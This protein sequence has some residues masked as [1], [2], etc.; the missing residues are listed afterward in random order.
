MKRFTV[1][2]HAAWILRVD[3]SRDLIAT[4]RF[5]RRAPKNTLKTQAVMQT[6]E[7]A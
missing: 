3:L 7:A 4:K 1:L 5:S 6:N 2:V